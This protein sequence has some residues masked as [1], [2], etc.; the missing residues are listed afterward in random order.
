MKDRKRQQ[1][2]Y[3]K[4]LTGSRAKAPGDSEIEV[5]LFGPGY[6]E[7]LAVHLGHGCWL[8]ADSCQSQGLSETSAPLDY[9]ELIGVDPASA[10]VL[11]VA[12]HWHDDHIRGL[13]RVVEKCRSADFWVSEALREEEFLVLVEAQSQA[14][15][16]GTSG[17]SEWR[18]I[19]ELLR[20][21]RRTRPGYEAVKWAIADRML[22]QSREGLPVAV[23]SLSPSDSA[24]SLAKH[25]LAKRLPEANTAKKRMPAQSPNDTAVV[26]WLDIAGSGILLGSDLEEEGRVEVGWSAILASR[27]RPQGK[28]TVF[29]IPHHG[30]QTAHHTGVWREMLG[31]EPH[32]ALTP[33]SKGGK[34][35]PSKEDVA[36]IIEFTPNAFATSPPRRQK[37]RF[38]DRA[39]AKTMRET[40]RSVFKAL[41]PF[42]HVRF[43]CE[44][45]NMNGNWR[46]ELFG[47]A[48][49]LSEI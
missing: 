7:S 43:R 5:S 29:K 23:T 21:R 10:V 1:Q 38:D 47:A 15:V 48:A 39:V 32:A 8:V 34:F 12:S 31:Q 3:E 33:W 14:M 13:S 17:L 41:P 18:A 2:A 49:P 20:S 16:R 35:L 40:T 37:A 11:V 42:G 30:S 28:A 44:M 46:Q 9:F 4:S 22:W 26:L 24:I 25:R 19:L 45:G 36:R 27:V 6:G